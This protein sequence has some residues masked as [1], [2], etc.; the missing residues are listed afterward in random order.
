MQFGPL[1]ARD[2]P[3]VLVAEMIF[4]MAG[5][6]GELDR[7]LPHQAVVDVL[8]P[9]IEEAELVAPTVLAVE[10]MVMRAAVDAQLLFLRCGAHIALGRPTQVQSPFRTSCRPPTSAD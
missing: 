3:L 1:R 6:D 7:R 9:V 10:R 2:R 5:T 4:A 8:E